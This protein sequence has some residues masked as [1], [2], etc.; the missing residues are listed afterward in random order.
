MRTKRGVAL[1]SS[2]ETYCTA[3]GGGD[4]QGPE[5]VRYFTVLPSATVVGLGICEGSMRDAGGA[6]AGAGVGV[7]GFGCDGGGCC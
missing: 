6:G 1:P 4:W 2:I 7:G 3:A 5:P